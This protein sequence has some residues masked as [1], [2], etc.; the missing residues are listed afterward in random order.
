LS[1]M[2]DF[3]SAIDPLSGSAATLFRLPERLLASGRSLSGDLGQISN[4]DQVVSRGRED[5][6]PVD[7]FVTA[8]PQLAQQP[9]GLQP[10]EDLFNP[11]AVPLTD[12]ITRMPGGATINCRATISVVLGHVRRYREGTQVFHEVMRV[13]VLIASQRYSTAAADLV[14]EGQS[15]LALRRASRCSHAGGDRQTVAILHQQMPGVAHLRLFAFTLAAQ[16]CFRI[17]SRL[18][19]LIRALLPVKVYCRVAGV[20]RRRFVL[21]VLRLE[22]LQTRRRFQQR[23]VNREV[24]IAKQLVP[25]RLRQHSGEEFRSDVAPQQALAILREGGRVPNLIVHVQTHEPAKQHVVVQLLHQQRPQ[26]LLRRDRGP[27]QGRIHFVEL[28]RQF[29][30]HGLGNLANR[31]QWVIL[32]HSLLWRQVTEHSRLL[33]IVSTHSLLFSW[34]RGSTTRHYYVGPCSKVTFSAAC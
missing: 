28:W 25:A 18:M 16:H 21:L 3:L 8:V 22:T 7:S 6:D 32:R 31:A 9:D 2:C 4:A 14:S 15:R 12:L 29:H 34:L 30:E 26:Q 5:E 1:M 20:I 27:T 19:G 24:L 33:Q 11:F 10:T 13:I 23:T 17:S